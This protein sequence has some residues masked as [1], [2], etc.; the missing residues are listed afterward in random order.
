MFCSG[1]MIPYNVEGIGQ[2]LYIDQVFVWGQANACISDPAS[3]QIS[4]NLSLQELQQLQ[5]LNGRRE[6][7]ML[8]RHQ[9]EKKRLP[10]IQKSEMKTRNQIFK[11]SLRISHVMTGEQEREK[12]RQVGWVWFC[13]VNVMTVA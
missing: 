12:I 3:W 6:E 10:K 5:H 9:V 7:E 4:A 1:V 8:R 11:Q 2:H 13:G